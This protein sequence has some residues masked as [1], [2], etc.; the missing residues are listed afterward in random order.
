MDSAIAFSDV[1]IIKF[2]QGLILALAPRRAT[3]Y[4]NPGDIYVH[5]NRRPEAK[6]AF[7]KYIELSPNSKHLADVKNRLIA[8]D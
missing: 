3:A 5:L 8:L 1:L 4:A 2:H 6:R 7:G